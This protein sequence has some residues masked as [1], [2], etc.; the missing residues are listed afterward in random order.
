MMPTAGARLQPHADETRGHVGHLLAEGSGR[1]LLPVPRQ[2]DL[3][4]TS[5]RSPLRAMRSASSHGPTS[6]P[7]AGRGSSV[8]GDPAGHV[9][10]IARRP[11]AGGLGRGVVRAHGLIVSGDGQ[12]SAPLR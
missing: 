3:R 6:A 10:G 12:G 5:G 1:D 7:R 2:G 9:T 8:A 11:G 4:A